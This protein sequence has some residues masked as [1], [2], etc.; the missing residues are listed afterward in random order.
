M[1][2]ENVKLKYGSTEYLKE[3]LAHGNNKNERRK[4]QKETEK[5]GKLKIANMKRSKV[6]TK[7][8]MSQRPS[9]SSNQFSCGSQFP[10]TV[11]ELPD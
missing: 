6:S 3:A 2:T 1:A 8:K 9:Y 7:K 10:E 5:E 11:D 4:K